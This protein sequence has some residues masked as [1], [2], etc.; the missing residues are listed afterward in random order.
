MKIVKLTDD[1]FDEFFQLIEKMVGEADFRQAKPNKEQIRLMTLIPNGVVFLAQLDTKLIGFIAGMTQRYFFSDRQK[2]TDMGFYVLPEYRGS[3]AALR[4]I[5]AFE[6]WSIEKGVDD[7]CIGQTTAV[8]IEKTQKFYTHLGYKT[9]GFNTVKHLHQEN[10]MCGGG[11]GGGIVAAIAVVAIVVTAIVAPE[12]LPAVLEAGG[13]A[14]AGEV[15]AATSGGVAA[16]EV[17]GA[18]AAEGA[19]AGSGFAGVSPELAAELGLQGTSG[20]GIE[21]VG[22]GLS[23]VEKGAALGAA[24]GGITSG[25][26]GRD[27]ITGALIGGATGAVGAGVGS[28]FGPIPGGAAAGITGAGLRG[29]GLEPMLRSGALGGLTS[30]ITSEF[31]PSGQDTT[32]GEDIARQVGGTALG[33]G[34]SSLFA[35]DAPT[36]REFIYGEAPSGG[37]PGQAGLVAP[38]SSALGQALRIGSGEP[39][40][41]IESPGGG[42]KSGRPVWNIASLRVKDETGGEA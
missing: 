16:G 8:D 32:L 5:H 9:V 7:I 29:Q 11:G 39:G 19:A 1:R 30:G 15:A 35:P 24:K 12:V 4:L 26:Q 27:P 17:A 18:A 38:G 13:E 10:G 22:T 20:L 14:A 21:G 36:S 34:V 31:F 6:E 25:V 40:A 3:R 42:E 28:E 37:I 33:Y 23:T 41:P 2:S